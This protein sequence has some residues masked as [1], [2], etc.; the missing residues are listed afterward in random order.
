MDWPTP[1]DLDPASSFNHEISPYS[2]SSP[3]MSGSSLGAAGISAAGQASSSAIGGLFNLGSSL[4]NAHNADAINRRTLDWQKE[5][6]NQ[7]WQAARDLGLNNPSQLSNPLNGG[8]YSLQGR[9]FAP[10]SRS[11]QHNIWN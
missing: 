8:F 4:I 3:S 6:W 2:S 10:S 9:T 1:N 5:K 7:S 11:D